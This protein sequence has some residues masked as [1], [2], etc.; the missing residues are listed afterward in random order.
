MR[1]VAMVA[2]ASMFLVAPTM[3]LAETANTN[4]SAEQQYNGNYHCGYNGN[5]MHDGRD[6]R[7][8]HGQ[9]GHMMNRNFDE[10]HMFYGITLTEQQRT[11]MRDLMRQHHQDRYNNANF[12]QHRENMHKL[13]T[14]SQF[15]EA[16]VRAQVQNMDQQAIER[17]VEMAK[18]HN[19]MYQLLTP[20][21]KAQL[22]KNYQQR[23]SSFD[24][25]NKQ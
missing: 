17:H 15:D 2:L 3:V 5:G 25:S 9:R 14:A 24:G 20:E 19:Q 7:G 12:R 18:V 11:Q 21:Q 8:H 22:E 10:S 1:K 16:A 6:Y 4:P 23:M 13:V